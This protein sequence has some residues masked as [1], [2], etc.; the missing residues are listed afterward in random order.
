MQQR[1]HE[2]IQHPERLDIDTLYG[3]RELVARYPYFQAARLLFLRNLFLLHDASFGEELRRAAPLVSDR[4]A[5]FE[6]IEAVN[7]RIQPEPLECEPEP[8]PIPDGDRTVSLI[9]SFLDSALAAESKPTKGNAPAADPAKDYVAYLMQLEDATP[10]S[11]PAES[12]RS[13]RSA[14]LLDDYLDHGDERIV[15]P[16]QETPGPTTAATAA[17]ESE[18]EEDYFTETLAKIYI[19]QGRYEK[20]IE[21]IRKLNLHHPKKNSYFADQIRFLQK[22]IINNK[23]QKQ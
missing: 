9:D 16:E 7:Y 22:L 14:S 3:L 19:K 8:A 15:L 4:R 12:G 6:M 1:I 11:A 2:L 10:A 5:L 23:Y 13:E 20:A 21:I 17:A 18:P